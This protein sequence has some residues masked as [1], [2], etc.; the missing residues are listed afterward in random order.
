MLSPRPI[1][2]STDLLAACNTMDAVQRRFLG[3]VLVR[4]SGE[5]P[6]LGETQSEMLITFASS[7][8]NAALAEVE[9]SLIEFD[10]LDTPSTAQRAARLQWARHQAE[11]IIAAILPRVLPATVA[12]LLA[13]LEGELAQTIH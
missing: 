1:L 9:L 6:G 2:T 3:R 5:V 4:V 12:A 11:V 13:T 7:L 10:D 8:A